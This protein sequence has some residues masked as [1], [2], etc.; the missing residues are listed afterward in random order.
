MH[1]ALGRM[2]QV[3]GGLAASGSPGSQ[4]SGSNV[5][6]SPGRGDGP[7]SKQAQNTSWES[8]TSK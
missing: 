2:R 7:G 6:H 1:P 5:R 3:L 4:L 8:T